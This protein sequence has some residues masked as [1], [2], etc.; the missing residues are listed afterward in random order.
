MEAYVL[1]LRKM[2]FSDAVNSIAQVQVKSGK[3]VGN[4]LS[5]LSHW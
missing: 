1:K 4:I 2:K 3:K 5:C